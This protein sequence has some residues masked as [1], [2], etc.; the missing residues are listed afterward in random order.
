MLNEQQ[1]KRDR[2]KQTHQSVSA[3]SQ[4]LPQNPR[5]LLTDPVLQGMMAIVKT[6]VE[7]K[8]TQMATKKALPESGQ[9]LQGPTN[10]L[11]EPQEQTSILAPFSVFNFYQQTCYAVYEYK[12]EDSEDEEEDFV[13]VEQLPTGEIVTTDMASASCV[14]RR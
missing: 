10:T 9:V 3:A 14:Q 8:P 4:P 12:R 13:S 1:K 5:V 11:A 2:A 6:S 7:K